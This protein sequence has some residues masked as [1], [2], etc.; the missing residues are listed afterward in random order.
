MKNHL[1][2]SFSFLLLI[3]TSV[4]YGQVVTSEL[5][6][7]P[8]TQ[9]ILKSNGTTILEVRDTG[10]KVHGDIEAD[11]INDVITI[12]QSL[13]LTTGWQDTG[14]SGTNLENGTYIVQISSVSDHVVGGGHF[15][16]YYSGVMSWYGWGTNSPYA[17][18]IPL[19]RTGHA[20]NWGRLYL[21]TKRDFHVDGGKVKL[22]IRCNDR[23]NSGS[24]NYVFK[25]KKII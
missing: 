17:D 10:I 13:H 12:T 7:L 24:Y 22:Q 11:N 14:I 4:I 8:D 19:H 16:E 25:F 18:E 6:V 21:R 3:A 1:R 5:E 9:T 23:N 15:S 20:P 2:Q